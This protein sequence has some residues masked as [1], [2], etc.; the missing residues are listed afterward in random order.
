V[1]GL[2]N[3]LGKKLADRWLTLLVLPGALYMAVAVAGHKLGQAHAFDLSELTHAVT[4]YAT[5]PTVKTVGGQIAL[6]AAVLAG[7]A[8]IGLTAQGLGSLIERMALA[9]GWQAWPSVPRLLAR[10]EVLRRR[11]RWDAAHAAYQ[12]ALQQALAPASADR[13]DPAVRQRAARIRSHIAVE[14]PERPSWSGDRIHAAALR[15]DRDLHLDLAILWPTLWLTLPVP[16]RDEITSARTA[17]TRATTLAAW[18]VL[19]APLTIWWWPAALISA[20]VALASRYHLRAA[21]DTYALL[22]EAATRLYTPALLDSLGISRSGSVTPE[23]G[24]ALMNQLTSL[25]P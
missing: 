20:V 25:T 13:P 9:P 5:S 3:E 12:A 6:L 8:G 11:R 18:S 10:S 2:L 16:V 23:L 7:A 17:M 1:G 14:R 15:L 21:T 22:L 4:T 24:D 19:Y